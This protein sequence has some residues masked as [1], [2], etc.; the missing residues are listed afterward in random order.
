MPVRRIVLCCET[1]LE[2][3]DPQVWVR[4]RKTA[5]DDATSSATYYTSSLSEE[6]VGK[7]RMAHRPR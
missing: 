4:H 1:R 3:E 7:V 2:Y 5:R 6:G